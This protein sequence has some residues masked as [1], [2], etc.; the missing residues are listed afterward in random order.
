MSKSSELYFR[1][2]KAQIVSVLFF[3]GTVIALP[4]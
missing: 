4:K 1:L 3:L 2:S